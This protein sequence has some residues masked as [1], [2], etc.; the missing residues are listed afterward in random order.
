MDGEK[1]LLIHSIYLLHADFQISRDD[2]MENVRNPLTIVMHS[3]I[4]Q[5]AAPPPHISRCSHY[6]NYTI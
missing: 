6:I 5:S 3:L 1:L 2:M 4:E